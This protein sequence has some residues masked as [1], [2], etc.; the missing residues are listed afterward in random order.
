MLLRNPLID[1]MRYKERNSTGQNCIVYRTSSGLI[2]IKKQSERK[3]Y[4]TRLVLL[5]KNFPFLH[6]IIG[7]Q[8]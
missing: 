3:L 4:P 7:K 6:G 5:V 8:F 1:W 2:K